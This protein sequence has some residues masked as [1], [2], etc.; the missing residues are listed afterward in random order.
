MKK[1]W[2][3]GNIISLIFALLANFLVGAQILNVPSIRDISD[4]YAT[5]L[6]PAGYAFSIWSLIYLLLVVFA[7]YQARDF[8]KPK[9]EN[10]LP[11]SIGPWFI[12]SSI[13]NGLWTFI[14]VSDQIILSAGIILLLAISLYAILWKLRIAIDDPPARVIIC[15]WWPLLIYTG[16]VTM[17][18]VVNIASLL[19]SF[20]V[21]LSP[22]IS[23]TVLLLVTIGLLVLLVKRNVRELLLASTWAIV[24]IG[25][26][27]LSGDKT[28]AYTACIAAIILLISLFI[29]AYRHRRSNMVK[30]LV[31]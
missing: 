25:V 2:Q 10:T 14:F 19:K 1:V 8:F 12:I 15:V 9:D 29:H 5:Y 13:C 23:C 22:L 30:N 31:H 21:I 7:V 24:A 20:D 28:V 17:A 3:I 27:Q 6:T 11:E 4:K 18:S 16:W 26:Q